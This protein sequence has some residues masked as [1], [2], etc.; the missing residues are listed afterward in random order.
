MSSWRK[1]GV[2]DAIPTDPP[3]IGAAVDSFKAQLG[4]VLELTVNAGGLADELVLLRWMVPET[5]ATSN[6]S[7]TGEWRRWREDAPMV[8]DAVAQTYSARYE[9]PQNDT[10]HWLLLSTTAN[11]ANSLADAECV[12]YRGSM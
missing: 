6:L 11:A 9:H 7:A 10:N 2:V 5:G 12:H 8:I 4:N 3:G 1:I